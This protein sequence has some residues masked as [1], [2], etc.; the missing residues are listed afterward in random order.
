MVK[1]VKITEKELDEILKEL[2]IYWK[3]GGEKRYVEDAY[4]YFLAHD[5]L[6]SNEEGKKVYQYL[7]DRV[8]YLWC[9]ET[10]NTD[11]III[12]KKIVS[13]KTLYIIYIESLTS[14]DKISDFV[15]KELGH[16]ITV[17]NATG[18]FSKKKISVINSSFRKLGMADAK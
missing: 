4:R 9:K 6:I 7:S 15:I 1:K 11:D 3:N 18:G 13:Q 14:S 10:N 12:R 8:V 2:P 5:E 17:F 16:T